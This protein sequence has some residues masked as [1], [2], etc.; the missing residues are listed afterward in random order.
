MRFVDASVFVHAYIKPKREL[1]EHELKIKKKAK[2]II[3]RI[4]D[5]EKV[6]L[7]AAQLTEIAN[8][9]ES[10]MPLENAQEVEEFLLTSSNVRIFGVAKKDYV[11]AMEMAKKNKA[12]L[13]DCVAAVIMKKNGFDEIYS[14][15][16]DFD[17]LGVKRVTD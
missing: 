17:R 16:H 5:G 14:F 15:D 11:K 8:L 2:E 12:G 10:F 6:A 3:K 7:T 1:K 9:L 4:N 13:N